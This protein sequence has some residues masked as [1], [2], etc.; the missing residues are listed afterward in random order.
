VGSLDATTSNGTI[1]VQLTDLAS[2]KPVRLQTTNGGVD[3]RMDGTP[4]G[5]V[6][7]LTTNGSITL[8]APA[9][10]NARLHATTTNSSVT[11][12]FSLAT[13]NESSKKKI[14]GNIGSGGPR[15]DLTTTN[16]QIR[17]LKM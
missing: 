13:T 9:S 12:D 11:T 4:K 14:D 6:R 2:D 16:G 17:V 8:R 15:I 5:D 10:L 1:R 3:L 7:A